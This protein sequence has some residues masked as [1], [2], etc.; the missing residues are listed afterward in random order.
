MPVARS[1]ARGLVPTLVLALALA[2]CGGGG[3]SSGA[4]SSGGGT[5]ASGGGGTGGPTTTAA[6]VDPALCPVKALDSV[7][8]PVSITFWHAMTAANGETLTALVDKYNASQTKVKVN[9]EFQGTY[10]ETLTKYVAAVRGGSLPQM[11]QME[12]TAQQTM[13]D[14][15]STVPIQA[16]MVA[17]GYA[18]TDFAPALL[19]QYSANGVVQTM[20]FQLSNPVLYYNKKLFRAAGLDAE[21]P[22][23]TL[24]E[25][26]EASRKIVASGVAP[27]AFSAEVQAWYLEQ[28][29]AK[30]GE[31]VVNNQ[32][33]RTARANE[34]ELD[35]V[36]FGEAL[37]W[38][39]TMTK[40]NLVKNV[41]KNPS[42]RDH[43]LAIASG[44]VAMTFGTSAA[45]G[46]VYQLL[47]NFPNVEVGVGPLPGAASGG[48]SVGGGSLYLTTKATDQ[49]KAAVWD[50]MKF[51]NTP[52]NQTAW[53]V[54][55]GYIPTRLSSSASPQIVQQWRDRPGFRVAYDQLA[56]AKA[57]VGGGGP[58]IGD[59]LG[60]RNAVEAAV[61]AVLAG[62]DP[63]QAQAT[64]QSAATK[65]ITDYNKR[66][67]G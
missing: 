42:G 11:V 64:A 22:P 35:G 34:A 53:H 41:G 46:T 38:L 19:G 27:R 1:A 4:P 49:Q 59:Y 25:V 9:L 21:K 57:P 48:V 43:L 24:S 12:E 6:K 20:P 62:A 55:T 67:G 15:R 50:L 39:S 61:E 13:M 65:A 52:E 51:L 44:D 14:S 28:F 45:L 23:A 18:L 31:P 40:E 5:E 16:C 66:V 29:M 7:T 36:A 58:L 47:P 54:G 32:N 37:R 17:D 26:L 30:A 10:D 2:A 3:D 60:F 56:N 63:A 8:S 33:G